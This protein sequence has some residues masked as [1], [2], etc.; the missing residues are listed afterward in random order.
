MTLSRI[1]IA[2][3]GYMGVLCAVALLHPAILMRRGQ[4][5]SRGARWSIALTTLSTI[6]AFGLGI[7]MYEDYRNQV[8]RDLFRISSQTGLLFET[9]EHL[10]FYALVLAWTGCALVFA[11][12]ED[13]ARRL[14][15]L[16]FGA[17]AALV[18]AVG[19]M[20]SIVASVPL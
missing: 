8:K 11:A 10:A 13:D 9:K 6:A 3:H 17:S 16:A 15:R 1:L 5:L 18:L 20:G 19:A 7:F 14:A 2:L 12:P 4:A